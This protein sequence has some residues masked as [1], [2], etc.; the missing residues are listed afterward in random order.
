LK[1]TK[2]LY[3]LAGI[4]SN[5]EQLKQEQLHELAKL[6][7]SLK[8]EYD[9]L[10]RETLWKK[11]DTEEI[12]K[13]IEVLEKIERKVQE[14]QG[15]MEL[16][17]AEMRKQIEVKQLRLE[18]ELFERDSVINIAEK[19]KKDIIQLQK[20]LNLGEMAFKKNR[21]ELEKQKF[22]STEIKERL[23]Q[24]HQKIDDQKKVKSF[25]KERKTCITKENTL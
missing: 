9:V 13:Q 18:E 17:F 7:I 16:S 6:L 25:F 11:K 2:K 14:K 22:K 4:D 20:K 19:L 12:A 21:K 23:N 3:N 15:S 24:I 10:I 1:N 5:V 8:S